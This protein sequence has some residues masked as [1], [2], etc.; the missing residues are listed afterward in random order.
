MYVLY[1][2]NRIIET[3]NQTSLRTEGICNIMWYKLGKWSF[4]GQERNIFADPA[5]LTKTGDTT[6][7]STMKKPA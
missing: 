7:Q 1:S 4:K 5:L 6:S 3:T 2:K